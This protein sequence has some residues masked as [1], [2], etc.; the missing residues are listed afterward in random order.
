MTGREL[1]RPVN[2]EGT[3]KFGPRFCKRRDS[4]VSN[5]GYD[6]PTNPHED[7]QDEGLQAI[8]TALECSYV[9]PNHWIDRLLKRD[10]QSCGLNAVVAQSLLIVNT[11]VPK[12]DSRKHAFKRPLS[13][14]RGLSLIIDEVNT[15]S[16]GRTLLVLVDL[17]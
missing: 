9:R 12:Y 15:S 17:I 11:L 3:R 6:S 10:L 13:K 1:P 16:F 2:A 5:A 8:D 4:P 14:K 7:R